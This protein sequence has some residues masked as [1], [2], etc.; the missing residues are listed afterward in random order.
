M[1]ATNWTW[2]QNKQFEDALAV[3]DEDTADRWDKVA[4]M[5]DGK[6][7]EEVKAH[8]DILVEDLERIEAGLVPIPNYKSSDS[9]IP[10]SSGRGVT[11]K[12][13]KAKGKRTWSCK[14]VVILFKYE[15]R[16]Y[17]SL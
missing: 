8:Y 14:Y 17:N 16:K 13:V 7:P 15:L 5:V 4:S 9:N 6:S 11:R 10:G 12:R 2:R 3:Y 1:A